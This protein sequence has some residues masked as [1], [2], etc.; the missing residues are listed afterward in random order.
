MPI[1][2]PARIRDV[3]TSMQSSERIATLLRD[4]QVVGSSILRVRDGGIRLASSTPADRIRV[5]GWNAL[6]EIELVGRGDGSFRIPR[7]LDPLVR[8]SDRRVDQLDGIIERVELNGQDLTPVDASW[9][10]LG[11]RPEGALEDGAVIIHL[12]E[13]WGGFALAA[14]ARVAHRGSNRIGLELRPTDGEW[15]EW[16]IAL[17]EQLHPNTTHTAPASQAVWEALQDWFFLIRGPGA[18]GFAEIKEAWQDAHTAVVDGETQGHVVLHEGGW[19]TLAFLNLYSRSWVGHQLGVLKRIHALRNRGHSEQVKRDLYMHCAELMQGRMAQ[20]GVSEWWMV[21]TCRTAPWLSRH[22]DFA[23]SDVGVNVS[24]QPVDVNCMDPLQPEARTTDVEVFPVHD[25]TPVHALLAERRPAAYL[26]ALDLDPEHYDLVQARERLAP[27]GLELHRRTFV[28]TDDRGPMMYGIIEIA[29]RGLNAFR[30]FDCI[31][32]VPAR[33]LSARDLESA[34]HAL[35][36]R[37][38]DF[39]R[40]VRDVLIEDTPR[41]YFVVNFEERGRIGLPD[42]LERFTADPLGHGFV[43]VIPGDALPAFLERIWESTPHA[44]GEPPKPA[45]EY[46]DAVHR[47]HQ[48]HPLASVAQE[49]P[50]SPG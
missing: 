14:N 27:C 44:T 5:R 9:T 19:G 3:L 35:T 13:D 48:R 42:Y 46:P 2:S 33:P 47:P 31:R 24:I 38:H 18:Q 4:G 41:D 10:G 25:L 39:F 23:R 8:R 36:L 50:S 49:P 7:R 1:I 28:A 43:W 40:G 15:S 20:E 11:V 6:Y 32:F 21:A 37:A 30:L 45:K 26:S 12:T 34:W 17:S 16:M 29:T 22:W